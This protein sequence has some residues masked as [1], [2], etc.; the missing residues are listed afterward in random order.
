MKNKSLQETTEAQEKAKRQLEDEVD[1]LNA[2]LAN[3]GGGKEA[4]GEGAQEQQ[5]KVVAQLRD[6]IAEKNNQIKQ[7]TVWCTD[8]PDWVNRN[9]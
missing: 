3:A 1:A 6:Q 4:S 8:S 9:F 5:Q 2:R 7:L